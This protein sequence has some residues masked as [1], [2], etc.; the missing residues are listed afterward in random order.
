MQSIADMFRE[1]GKLEGEARGIK[2]GKIEGKIEAAQKLIA[3]GMPL[4]EVSDI[5]EIPVSELQKLLT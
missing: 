4:E 3:R 5:I 1:E 2:K